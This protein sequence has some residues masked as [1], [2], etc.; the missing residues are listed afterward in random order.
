LRP[1][2]LLD[3]IFP[4]ACG[5][6]GRRGQLWCQVCADS[7][8]CPPGDDL[9]GVPL[10]AAGLLEGPFQRAIHNYKYR[11][12]AALADPLARPLAGAVKQAGIPLTALTYV[13][14]HPA[15]ARQRGFN[16]AELV[17]RRL[18]VALGLP[19]LP[20]LRRVRATDP[21]VGL[22]AREREANL[23]SAFTWTSAEAAPR[24]VGLVDDV[25]TTGATLLAAAAALEAAGGSIGAFLVLAVAH[26][27]P[28][29]LVTLPE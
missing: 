2:A 19:V 20:G 8:R 11:S 4:P 25:C 22:S 29:S 13:P 15:R 14:L 6:C 17:A 7:L 28:A 23:A 16:Q 18:G 27:L 3:L 1:S 9:R 5:G 26:T 24:E 21:Q 10:I 12:S